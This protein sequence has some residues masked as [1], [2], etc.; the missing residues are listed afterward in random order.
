MS[1][2]LQ[3]GIHPDADSLS[4]FIEGVLPE[5]EREAC[6]AHLAEC[7][8]CREIAYA[9]QEPE[10]EPAAA[11]VPARS[12]WRW[13][14]PV[15]LFAT[16]AI[17]A[18]LSVVVVRSPR[19][20]LQTLPQVA[21]DRPQ[22]QFN[23]PDSA[24]RMPAPAA[25][26][27]VTRRTPAEPR[28]SPF[29]ATAAASAAAPREEAS[30][31]AT[32]AA[33]L[34][35]PKAQAA[36][37]PL[38]EPA[39]QAAAAAPVASGLLP[40]KDGPPLANAL[41]ATARALPSSGITGSVTDVSGASIPGATITIRP[42]TGAPPSTARA[43]P[44]GEFTVV[45]L[46]PG[47]YEVLVSAPGF[48]TASRQVEVQ[49][50][51]I[52]KANTELPI[53][54]VTE[55]VEVSAESPRINTSTASLSSRAAKKISLNPLPSKRDTASSA[56]KDKTIVSA[57][58]TGVLFVSRNSGKSWKAVTPVWQGKVIRVVSPPEGAAPPKTVFQ[59]NTDSGD[60]WYSRDGNRWARQ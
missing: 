40:P 32:P 42:A 19:P 46:P 50:Q 34:P 29:G 13:L 14:V 24:A 43:N 36:A 53:G 22:S 8:A 31:D 16:A 18:I 3:P 20:A 58:D 1:D 15:S 10:P 27:L 30:K 38:A 52:A 39:G 59:L 45:P 49:P 17:A 4:A 33:P 56:Q 57:D 26:K 35:E 2:P 41:S 48:Q 23:F 6:L 55:T 11:E 25:K 60:V 54:S 21:Q 37:A 5:H 28:P 44:S 47:R 7:A 51:L 9:A 12:R